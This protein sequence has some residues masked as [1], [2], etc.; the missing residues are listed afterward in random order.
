[1]SDRDPRRAR[2]EKKVAARLKQ[3]GYGLDKTFSRFI[4]DR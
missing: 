4:F 2:K 3:L 1:M